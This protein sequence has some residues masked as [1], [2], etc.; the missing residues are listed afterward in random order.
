VSSKLI[1]K[2]FDMA[3]DSRV[4]L[5]LSGVFPN[6]KP[7]YLHLGFEPLE[8]YDDL[9]IWFPETIARGK[10]RDGRLVY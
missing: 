1:S 6:A 10:V 4:P 8:G 5:L 7:G 2:G 9:M 3:R